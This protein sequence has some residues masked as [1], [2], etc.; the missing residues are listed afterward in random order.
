LG[1]IFDYDIICIL[2]TVKKIVVHVFPVPS[3][4]FPSGSLM[5]DGMDGSSPEQERTMFEKDLKVCVAL[6]LIPSCKNSDC[7]FIG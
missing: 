1:K 3:N 7:T 6:F 2:R 4:H 5:D